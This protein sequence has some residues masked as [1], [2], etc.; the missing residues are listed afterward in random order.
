[1]CAGGGEDR[2]LAALMPDRRLRSCD[3][4]SWPL[5][6]ARAQRCSDDSP[7]VLAGGERNNRLRK[8]A[9]PRGGCKTRFLSVS[10][11]RE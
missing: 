11:L 4:A 1:M 9:G 2:G 7:C 10:A 6:D 5:L 8:S 3:A